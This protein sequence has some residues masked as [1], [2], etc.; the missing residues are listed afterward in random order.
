MKR[1]KQCGDTRVAQLVKRLPLAQVMIP[2]SWGLSPAS[3]SLLVREPASPSAS[4]WHSACARSLSLSL[5]QINKIFKNKKKTVLSMVS[6]IHW[7]PWNIS[8][9]DK[10]EP[11]YVFLLSIS[12][13]SISHHLNPHS[14]PLLH[15]GKLTLMS[16]QN[17]TCKKIQLANW[18]L[19][20]F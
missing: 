5:W 10:G 16:V 13:G 11:L 4:A 7:G 8:P 6:G 12:N 17:Y 15:C 20:R 18:E 14:P 2:A 19:I 3:G 9:E 1:K